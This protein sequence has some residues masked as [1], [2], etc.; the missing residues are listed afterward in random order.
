MPP[1]TLLKVV[2][3][4]RRVLVAFGTRPEAIKLMPVL[5]ALRP[6]PGLRA[7]SLSTG[8]HGQLLDAALA[9]WGEVPDMVLPG[10]TPGQSL[11]ALTAR[12][13]ATTAEA[14]EAAR[15]DLVLVQGDTASAFAVAVAAHH[16][17]I[18]VGHVEAGLRS[19]QLGNPWPEEFYRVTVDAMA[20]LRFAP[21][22]AAAV[23]LRGEYGNGRVLVTGNTGIDALLAASRRLD[24]D[25]RLAASVA[26]ALPPPDPM[27]Q[28]VMVTMHRRESLGA[29]LRGVCSALARLAARRDV[30]IAWPLHP[31]P[32]VRDVA[33]AELAGAGRV[34]LLP[35]LS[36]LQT[37][38]L[39]R[40]SAFL[41]SD[42][43]GLQEEAPALGRPVLILRD[44]TE[45][46]EA[47]ASGAAA[48]IGTAPEAILRA[49]TALLD[50]PARLA[51][52]SRPVFPFGDGR[53]AERIAA[54][55]EDFGV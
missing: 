7:I 15:P 16:A 12:I 17:R 34:H 11:S 41:M 30:E 46:P 2:S 31:N 3:A 9:E 18:P 33:R 37:V 21:T 48:L 50:D 25:P 44:A 24:A 52:M 49:A 35:P 36:Y 55:L 53:A 38:A 1:R 14:I 27:R 4:P 6:M 45:R 19:G 43:G 51:A 10:A 54:A 26:A 40:R 29:P 39:M 47:I 32:A 20:A 42:S 8:Q 13:L 23:R 28:L 5:A 22:Q